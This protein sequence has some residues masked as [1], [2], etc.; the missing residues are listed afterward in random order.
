MPLR[1]AFCGSSFFLATMQEKLLQEVLTALTRV[2]APSADDRLAINAGKA[3]L[4]V[5]ELSLALLE[6]NVSIDLA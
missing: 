3:G 6:R 4:P 1:V 5:R 2:I